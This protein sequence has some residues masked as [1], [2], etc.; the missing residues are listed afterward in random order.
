MSNVN[1]QD[2]MTKIRNLLTYGGTV[3]NEADAHFRATGVLEH[4]VLGTVTARPYS[5]AQKYA[6]VPTTRPASSSAVRSSTTARTPDAPTSST[7]R[8]QRSRAR[9]RVSR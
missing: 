7:G 2:A 1:M 3:A 4:S 9:R 6:P 5:V 8:R